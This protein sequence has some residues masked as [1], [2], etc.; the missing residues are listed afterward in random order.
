MITAFMK[1]DVFWSLFAMPIGLTICFGPA[2]IAW[3]LSPAD[4]SDEPIKSPAKR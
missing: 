4:P 1:A 3:L 2:L